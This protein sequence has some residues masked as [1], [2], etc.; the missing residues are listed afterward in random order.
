M[1]ST[2]T[3]DFQTAALKATDLEAVEKINV[4]LETELA[5]KQLNIIADAPEIRIQDKTGSAS[6]TTMSIVADGGTTHFRAG[7]DTFAEG[8]ETKGNVKFQSSTGATTH[9]EIV[10]SSGT[11]E[12]QDGGLGLKLGSNVSVTGTSKVIQEITG[13]HTRDVSVLKRY[14]EMKMGE[15]DNQTK[16]GVTVSSSSTAF[17]TTGFY[18]SNVYNQIIADEGWHTSG[19]PSSVS[20]SAYTIGGVTGEWHKTEFPNKLKVQSF[21]I[22]ARYGFETTQAPEDLTILGSNDDST[23]VSLKSVTG[24][25]YTAYKYTPV[26]IDATEYYKYLAVVVTDTISGNQRARLVKCTGWRRRGRRG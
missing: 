2:H 7:V 16:A 24:L 11:L 14:P 15:L 18:N 17:N 21:H 8:T 10:G 13:P 9:A 19:V 20:G 22:A 26:Q 23:W 1:P 3:S 25:S 5:R 6:E 4:G 12:L